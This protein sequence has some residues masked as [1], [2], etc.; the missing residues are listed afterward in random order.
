VLLRKKATDI[1]NGAATVLSLASNRK[2]ID[3]LTKLRNV[4]ALK[5]E[6]S[7]TDAK[8]VLALINI[9]R[10]SGVNATYGIDIGDTLLCE[11]GNERFS[12]MVES[13]SNSF[14]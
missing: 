5:K 8:S 2:K 7:K 11:F 10:F 3:P 12:A 13:W 4:Y 1:L 6:F 14:A 9:D